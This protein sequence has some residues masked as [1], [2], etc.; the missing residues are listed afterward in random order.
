[1]TAYNRGGIG[2]FAS[3]VGSTALAGGTFRHDGQ[4]QGS[5]WEVPRAL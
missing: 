3:G 4:L 5:C 2:G 1:M